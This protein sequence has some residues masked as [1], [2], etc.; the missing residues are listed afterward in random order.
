MQSFQTP[1]KY[2]PTM[3]M[4]ALQNIIKY[5]IPTAAHPD[6]LR[7]ARL[8]SVRPSSDDGEVITGHTCP[9][10]VEH[11]ADSPC[12]HKH[13][14]T[15]DSSPSVSL[16]RG[17]QIRGELVLVCSSCMRRNR[18]RLLRRQG[19]TW[20]GP[21]STGSRGQEGKS[22]A[23]TGLGDR[24]RGTYHRPWLGFKLGVVGWDR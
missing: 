24:E 5:R 15:L 14:S 3:Q 8:G 17:W 7:S 19:C 13:P 18:D 10:P 22:R 9:R 2:F 21:V 11:H 23:Q 20:R 4:P 12:C 16:L 6:R 1:L